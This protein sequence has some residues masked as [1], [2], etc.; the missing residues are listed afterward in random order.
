MAESVEFRCSGC[1]ESPVL[2]EGEVFTVEYRF[3]TN[4]LGQIMV[5][6]AV[7]WCPGCLREWDERLG[8]DPR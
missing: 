6:T 1:G 7:C 4:D 5:Q 3:T 2:H 8:F